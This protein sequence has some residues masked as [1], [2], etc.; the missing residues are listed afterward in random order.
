MQQIEMYVTSRWRWSWTVADARIDRIDRIDRVG[1]KI[2][3][4]IWATKKELV[5][6]ESERKIW[7]SKS[8]PLNETANRDGESKV[9][10]ARNDGE[11][12]EL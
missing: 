3:L 8:S 9:K 5:I 2:D 7:V 10:S 11:M 4:V 12:N 1:S 6:D